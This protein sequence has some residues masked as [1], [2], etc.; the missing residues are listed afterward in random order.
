MSTEFDEA[1]T[2]GIQVLDD[3]RGLTWPHEIDC[4]ELAQYDWRM[5]VIGQ[6]YD[7][8]ALGLF[9][10][11]RR[12]DWSGTPVS[13]GIHHGFEI[14]TGDGVYRTLADYDALT[15][16]WRERVELLRVARSA[17]SVDA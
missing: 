12:T 15:R 14:E 10:L 16:I 9:E 11:M 2:R 13:F 8:Y 3:A 4:A 7:E 17:N 5:C 6:L 1:V